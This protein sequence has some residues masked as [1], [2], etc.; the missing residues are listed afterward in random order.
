MA[1]FIKACNCPNCGTLCLDGGYTADLTTAD[2]VV[3]IDNFSNASW[4]CDICDIDFGTADV[5]D[6]IE[7]F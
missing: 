1:K 3:N 6:Y 4:H 7:E 5:M 2:N